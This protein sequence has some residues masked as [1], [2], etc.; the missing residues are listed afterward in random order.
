LIAIIF[1]SLGLVAN[2]AADDRVPL[3]Y[4]PPKEV[5]LAG[6]AVQLID[7]KEAA[8]FLDDP[9]TVFVDSRG[10]SEYAISRV[11]GS[12]CLPPEDVEV[13]FPA[14]EPLL[15]SES[16]IILYCHGPECDMAERVGEFLAR[17]GYR[18]LFIMSSGFPAWVKAKYP[19]EGES[20]QDTASK[21]IE[22]AIAARVM[23]FT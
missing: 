10:C 4:T 19:I 6:V 2:R 17:L 23:R 13:R 20:G 14:V 8:K 22:K 7:E 1:A 21:D 16:R 9:G 15:P 3:V 18:N 12:V 11:K 5:I